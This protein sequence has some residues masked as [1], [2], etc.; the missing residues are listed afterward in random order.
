MVRRRQEEEG[1]S[2]HLQIRG[3]G[4]EHPPLLQIEWEANLGDVSVILH[5]ASDSY[6]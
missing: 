1:V 5:S 2:W 4:S 6:K 3:F